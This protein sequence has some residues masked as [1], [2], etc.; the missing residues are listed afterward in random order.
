MKKNPI[1]LAI[2]VTLF[3]GWLTWLGVQALGAKKPIV[4]SRAQLAT[5]QYDVEVDLSDGPLPERVVVRRVRWSVD[6]R[7]PSGE[8]RV[9][10]LAGAEGFTGPGTYLVPLLRKGPDYAV[11]HFP[12]D[13]GD[14]RPVAPSPRIYPATAEVLAQWDE[15]RGR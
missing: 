8:I 12:R 2:A 1:V 11:A 5:S 4:V 15:A 13:P 3:A 7:P 6:D 9:L 10:N 14:P